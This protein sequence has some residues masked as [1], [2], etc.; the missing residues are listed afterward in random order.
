[1]GKREKI[2]QHNQAGEVVIRHKQEKVGWKRE[3]LFVIKQ[4]LQS[5]SI[6]KIAN[7]MGRS[8]QTIQTWIN[9]YRSGG[10]DSLLDK[11]KGNG[12]KSKLTKEIEEALSKELEKGKFRTARQAWTWLNKHFDMSDFKESSIYYILGKCEGRLKQPRPS[13]PKKD[14]VKEE[15][16]KVTLADKITKLNLPKNRPIRLWV[17]D[18]MR[19]GLHPLTRKVWC[20][21]GIRATAPSRRSFKNGYIY[22]ALQVGGGGSEFIMTPTLNKA[23]D[24]AFLKQISQ[25]DPYA[26]HVV[27][28]DGAGFH[29]KGG[30]ENLPENVHII[31]LPPYCPELNPVEKLWDIIKDGVCNRDWQTMAE[32]EEGLIE[33]LKPYWEA[34][35]KVFSLF[36]NS[37]LKLQLKAI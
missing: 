21:R 9:K 18:E 11:Q 19:Y 25:R 24:E 31:Q 5:I 33:N 3:R 12:A 26:S 34:P 36:A 30:D 7:E 2:D 13:N 10:I 6:R 17:Y 20:K 14:P 22:G 32:L 29:H 27:I 1:M 37:Y 23:W 15:E 35:K 8:P 4:A 16:F 28:G